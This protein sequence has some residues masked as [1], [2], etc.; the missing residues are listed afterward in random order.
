MSDRFR[1]NAFSLIELC[2]VLAIIS[3]LI[4]IVLM[5]LSSARKIAQR[6]ECAS[7]MH[8]IGIALEMYSNENRGWV[9]RDLTGQRGD[10][11]SWLMQAAIKLSPPG[12]INDEAQLSQMPVLQCPSHPVLGIPSGFVINAFAFETQ[13]RWLPDGP[14][15]KSKLRRSSDLPWVLEAADS[16]VEITQR[17]HLDKIHFMTFHD[18]W[19]PS[20]LPNGGKHRISDSRHKE[21]A[22]VLY[23]DNH[24]ALIKKGDLKLDDFDDQLR[25]RA[26]KF[27][28]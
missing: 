14:I 23:A 25:R 3:Y 17:E 27:T 13:P 24:V 15:I 16:F 9:P 5:V 6:T 18:V 2:I 21:T 26:T 7:R 8:Q 20:H 11:P 28:P 12:A 19:S 1:K 22:N 10:R 4:A